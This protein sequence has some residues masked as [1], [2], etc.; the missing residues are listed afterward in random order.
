MMLECLKKEQKCYLIIIIQILGN[1]EAENQEYVRITVFI[2]IAL[3]NVSND[4]SLIYR[5]PYRVVGSEMNW[6]TRNV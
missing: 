4:G 3:G 2:C 6:Q 5:V 1:R